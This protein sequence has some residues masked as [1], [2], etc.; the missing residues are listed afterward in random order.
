MSLH[1]TQKPALLILVERFRRG[2]RLMLAPGDRAVQTE[3]VHV[4][5]KAVLSLAGEFP[6]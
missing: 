6:V 3:V 2:G 4:E 1:C 5:V